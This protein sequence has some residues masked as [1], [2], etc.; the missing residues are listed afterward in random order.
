MPQPLQH[1][2][3][4]NVAPDRL[5]ILDPLTGREIAALET[6]IPLCFNREGG[7]LLTQSDDQTVYLWDLATI[8]RRLAEL[9]LDWQGAPL[10]ASKFDAPHGAPARVRVLGELAPRGKPAAG[11]RQAR[12]E[13]SQPGDARR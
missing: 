12:D 5:Q 4:R 1:A 2:L 11:G 10:P 3:K 8:R 6:N 9:N 13:D 7:L